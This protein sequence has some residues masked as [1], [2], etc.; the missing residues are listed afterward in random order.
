MSIVVVFYIKSRTS[1]SDTPNEIVELDSIEG[2]GYVLEDRDTELY[3]SVFESLRDT[4]KED[5][6][7]YEEYAKLLSELYVIDLYTIS[8]KVNK[9][10]VGSVDF[11]H[12]DAKENFQEKV[13]DTI[14]KYVED[15]SYGK[16]NQELP[17]VSKVDVD[18]IEESKFDVNGTKIDGYNVTLSWEY[19]ED[20]GYDKESTISLVNIDNKLYIIKEE[21]IT[22]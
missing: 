22:E 10:D 21:C 4:L 1:T 16:R 5:T 2:Y 19:E 13:K 12:E 14:Y 20:Y 8:N 18:D 11:L 9:Y 6:I 17:T 3:K 7:D 15:N